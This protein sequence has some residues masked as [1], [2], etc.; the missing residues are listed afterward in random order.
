[1]LYLA[2]VLNSGKIIDKEFKITIPVLMPNIK[3]ADSTET[4]S[5]K[6]ER[7]LSKSALTGD[8][9]TTQNYIIAKTVTDYASRIDDANVFSMERVDGVTEVE[10][11]NPSEKQLAAAD[12]KAADVYTPVPMMCYVTGSPIM[13]HVHRILAPMKF[14]KMKITNVNNIDIKKGDSCVVSKIGNKF[15][16][17]KFI[18]KVPQDKKDFN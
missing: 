1:M 14:Y 10:T 17:L 8:N 3:A 2:K 5:L 12:Y 16:I 11:T 18:D 4:T 7:I 6:T 13:N 15:F 9:I